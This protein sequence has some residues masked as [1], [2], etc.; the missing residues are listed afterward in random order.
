MKL[1]IYDDSFSLRAFSDNSKDMSNGMRSTSGEPLTE[2]EIEVVKSE[3]IRI[4]ADMSL[5]VFN[6]PDH[7]V[8]STCYNYVEDCVYITRNVFPDD[9][10]GSTHPR[11]LMSVG[12]VIAHEYYGHRTYR[13]EY[14]SDAKVGAGY[15]TT[16]IWQDE[17]RASITA[18]KIAPNLTLWDKSYLVLDAIYRAKEAGHIIE[19]DDFM[20]EAVYG[21]TN[22]ENNITFP[23]SPIT[24]ISETGEI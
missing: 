7:L 16:P 14:L 2:D 13:D 4:E 11:D 1:N 21:Y 22:D 19:M 12:A 10:F 24:Y 17:C 5:F 3:I 15:H 18:A 9:R 8:H 6:D 23:I 20:K